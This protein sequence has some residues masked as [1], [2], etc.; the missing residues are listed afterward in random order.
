MNR[1]LISPSPEVWLCSQLDVHQRRKRLA[2]AGRPFA[3]VA[4]GKGQARHR[5]GRIR[6]GTKEPFGQ[7]P[8]RRAVD[9]V[10]HIDG[11]PDD[12]PGK[13]RP[14][15]RGSMGGQGLCHLKL[16]RRSDSRPALTASAMRLARPTES[17]MLVAWRSAR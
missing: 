9:Q 1:P 14:L 11:V 2:D 17:V 5:T 15:R 4:D 6:R 3:L 10:A 16:P 7:R 13:P 12:G 8:Q